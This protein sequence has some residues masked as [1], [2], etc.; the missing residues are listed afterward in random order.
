MIKIGVALSGGGIRSF[1]QL[2]IMKAIEE[3]NI[4]ISSLAGTSMGSVIAGLLACGMSVDDVSEAVLGVEKIISEKRIFKRIG[5]KF[6]PFAK[7]KIYGGYV[8]GA[9]LESLLIDVLKPL[10]IEM[11][12]DVKIPLAIPA[13]DIISGKTI[14]FVSHPQLFTKLDENWIVVSDIPLSLAIR[15]SCSF[16]FVIGAALYEDYK[17]VDGGLTMNLPIPLLEAY[18]ME[19]TIGVTMHASELFTQEPSVFPLANRVFDIMRIAAD[20]AYLERADVIM[21]VPLDTIQI[22]E[23]GKGRKTMEVGQRV[24]QENREALKNI[25]YKKPWYKRLLGKK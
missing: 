6:L 2:P 17:L 11:I 21:N 19:R 1:S 14:V 23:I 3:D 24:A 20:E 4:I 25:I 9:E 18:G 10:K 15:A 12:T 8:D 16:P 5:R 7:D 22:F 13:V